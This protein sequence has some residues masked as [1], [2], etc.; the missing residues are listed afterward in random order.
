MEVI[1]FV[2]L[3]VNINGTKIWFSDVDNSLFS[4]ILFR[5]G[6]YH[7]SVEPFRNAT[8]MCNMSLIKRL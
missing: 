8:S 5:Y 2:P 4:P 3:C 7:I 1:G 6:S